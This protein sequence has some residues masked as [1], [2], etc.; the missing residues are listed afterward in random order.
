MTRY[1][2]FELA[3]YQQIYD[4]TNDGNGIFFQ[5]A[6]AMMHTVLAQFAVCWHCALVYMHADIHVTVVGVGFH[7]DSS[8]FEDHR[9]RLRV[10][11]KDVEGANMN[12][13]DLCQVL[14]QLTKEPNNRTPLQRKI[15]DVQV[16]VFDTQNHIIQVMIRYI[17]SSGMGQ[18]SRIL[19]YVESLTAEASQTKMLNEYK[20]LQMETSIQELKDQLQQQNSTLLSQKRMILAHGKTIDQIIRKL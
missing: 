15:L 14:K 4:S 10:V 7:M 8:D 1:G 17:F 18:F 3:H 16:N 13:G 9:E 6:F 12:V 2:P 19:R 20:M 5:S 11:W